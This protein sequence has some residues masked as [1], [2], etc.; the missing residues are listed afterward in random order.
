M[1]FNRS[2]LIRFFDNQNE[3]DSNPQDTLR[4][5]NNLELQISIEERID[6][7]FKVLK[8]YFLDNNLN[9]KYATFTIT[10]FIYLILNVC[11]NYYSDH[12]LTCLQISNYN[13]NISNEILKFC[14]NKYKHEISERSLLI[15]LCF[16]QLILCFLNISVNLLDNKQHNY[17][18]ILVNHFHLYNVSV[19]IFLK[20]SFLLSYFCCF[21]FTNVYSNI[22]AELFSKE[23]IILMVLVEIYSILCVFRLFYF[24]IKAMFSVL[25]MPIFITVFPLAIFEDKLNIKL[26]E[27]IKTEVK[28]NKNDKLSKEKGL[29]NTLNKTINIFFGKNPEE[30]KNNKNKEE[31]EFEIISE[32]N[33]IGNLDKTKKEHSN[34]KSKLEFDINFNGLKDDKSENLLNVDSDID[35]NGN[36]N[37]N[38]NRISLNR[39]SNLKNENE[40]I[41]NNDELNRKSILQITCAICLNDLENN[42]LIST[43]PCNSK[44]CY[45]TECLQLW[46]EKNT[47]CPICRYDFSKEINDLLGINDE[48]NDEINDL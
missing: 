3:I 31:N 22:R 37:M 9:D 21:I 25:I 2:F 16:Y 5:L 14:N 4:N 1:K 46:F 28:S 40:L 17:F 36:L 18:Y 26:N 13:Y 23:P 10:F 32:S 6:K 44:H 35:I 20:I 48:E 8:T 39:K 33:K 34:E 15:S 42:N 24:F 12:D 41:E 11:D 7:T 45:H 19:K 43:L 30:E 29:N 47:S 38:I 27:I